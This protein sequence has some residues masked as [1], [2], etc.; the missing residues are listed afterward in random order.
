MRAC[1]CFVYAHR[2]ITIIKKYIYIR[3]NTFCIRSVNTR[4]RAIHYPYA[5]YYEKTSPTYRVLSEMIAGG[6]V[7]LFY[8]R[9]ARLLQQ[10]AVSTVYNT[11][12][13]FFLMIS[14]VRNYNNTTTVKCRYDILTTG[15]G[16]PRKKQINKYAL[17]KIFLRRAPARHYAID[18]RTQ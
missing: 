15:G 10:I 16:Q 11:V 1:L 3:I 9:P 13:F 12:F 8:P 5:Y 7:R 6:P 14:F 4:V 17:P 2:D 18:V